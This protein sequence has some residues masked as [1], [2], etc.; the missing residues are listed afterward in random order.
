MKV[1]HANA[2]VLSLLWLVVTRL[3][4]HDDF[5]MERYRAMDQVITKHRVHI[6]VHP[7][8]QKTKEWNLNFGAEGA[9]FRIDHEDGAAKLLADAW[10]KLD[11]NAIRGG[12]T[13]EEDD[14][15]RRAMLDADDA[16]RRMMEPPALPTPKE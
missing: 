16:I 3:V 7:M 6:P 15:H 1:L 5:D 2:N 4:K 14:V 8:D 9:I 12:Q 13:P 11:K 10:K